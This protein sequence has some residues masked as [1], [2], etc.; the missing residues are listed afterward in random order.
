M[1][2]VQIVIRDDWGHLTGNVRNAMN[3]VKTK[4]VLV[5]H[6]FPFIQKIDIH[7]VIQD[8]KMNLN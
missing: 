7:K 4:Y 3:Y 1:D 5:Q 6:D 8:M 2:N